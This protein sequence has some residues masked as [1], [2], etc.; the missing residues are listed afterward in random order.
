MNLNSVFLSFSKN[1]STFLKFQLILVI[2]FSILYWLFDNILVMFPEISEELHFGH[3]KQHTRVEPYY[4]WFWHSLITQTTVGYSGLV[5]N[6]GHSVSIITNQ[7]N[8]YKIIN[9]AQLISIFVVA[10]KFM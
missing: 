8:I 9:M 3:Y 7:S 1:G 5:N 6:N 4:Y 2:V 10:A